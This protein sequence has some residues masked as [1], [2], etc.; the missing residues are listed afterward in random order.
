MRIAD[1]GR[2]ALQAEILRYKAIALRN[3]RRIA[4]LV[5]AGVFG[6]LALAAGEV[7]LFFLFHLDARITPAWSAV[8]VGGIDLGFALLLVV[9][10]SAGGPGP[11][12]IEA[13]L[14]RDRA[15]SELRS[16][17]AFSAVTGPAG[18][19]AG[20]GFLG[21]VRRGVSRRRRR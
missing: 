20:R 2:T 15:L 4:L 12:E 13:R 18:R 11:V 3:V 14:T 17:V 8:I 21:L 16:A 19:L 6:L 9:A 1:L 7:A 5:I 10:G